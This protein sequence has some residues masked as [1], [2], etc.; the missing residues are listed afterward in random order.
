MSN[1]YSAKFMLEATTTLESKVFQRPVNETYLF[2]AMKALHEMNVAINDKTKILYTQ[3]NEA[4]SKEEENKLFAE[5]FFQFKDIFTDFS[6]RMQQLKSRMTIAIE[7]KVETWQDLYKDDAYISSFDKQFSY[8]GYNFSHVDDGDYPRLNL[9]KLYQKEFDYLGQLMQDT[10][11]N[12]SPSV[13]LKIIASVANNFANASRDKNWIKNLIHDMIDIDEKDVTHSYSECIY[14]ALRNKEDINVDRG[15]LY[16]C[17][18]SLCDYEDAINAASKLC[19][20]VLHELDRVSENI[21]SFLFRNKDNKLK[22]KTDTDGIIDRDYRIDTYSMNQLDLFMKNKITQIKKILNVFGVA[23]GIKFDTAVDYID[24]NIE[25]LKAA[26]TYDVNEPEDD[27]QADNMDG[28]DMST[29]EPEENT[30]DE[31][32]EEDFEDDSDDDEDSDDDDEDSDDEEPEDGNDDD[33]EFD[34]PEDFDEG[35]PIEEDD[36]E[37]DFGEEEEPAPEQNNDVVDNDSEDFHEAYLFE[38]E[39][40]ELEMMAE[41]YEMH[42]SIIESVLLEETEAERQKREAKEGIAQDREEGSNVRKSAEEQEHINKVKSSKDNVNKLANKAKDPNLFQ[43]IIAKIKELWGKFKEKFI[44]KTKEKIEYLNANKKFLEKK[45][46]GEAALKYTPEFSLF[47]KLTIPDLDYKNAHM[48]KNLDDDNLF[49]KTYFAQ[50][51]NHPRVKDDTVSVTE[52][53]KQAVLGD[54]QE[55][56]E[57]DKLS[58]TI[59]QAMKYCLNYEK[60]INRIQSLMNTLNNAEKVAKDISN[61]EGDTINDEK[62]EETQNEG[63]ESYF[64]EFKG[65]QSGGTDSVKSGRVKRYFSI[66]TR[67]LAAYMTVCNNV[68]NEMYAFCKWHITRARGGNTEAA[69][70]AGKKPEE[71]SAENKGEN[72]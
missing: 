49:S 12:A 8:S 72:K 23:I 14:N 11:M 64:M 55:M 25:I 36:G 29:E 52:A 21:A 54:A 61:V 30:E 50:F 26:K 16:K 20:D 2:S 32:S 28:E 31:T 33:F 34:D 48:Q 43:R 53:I 57:V 45:V 27:S 68:F 3:I 40:F 63:F 69:A 71:A 51:Y 6:N 38:A 7:N 17:K 59:D 19:D 66:T 67:A 46:T 9:H 44:N 18:E 56:M 37:I 10:S 15:M 60:Y 39:L 42:Q 24:Q 5:Y 70:N 62:K 1:I 13:R 65:G 22:I 47:D 41:E 4:E 58:T 35:E